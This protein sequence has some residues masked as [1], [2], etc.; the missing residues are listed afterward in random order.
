MP[1]CPE[2]PHLATQFLRWYCRSELLDEVEGDLYELF[3]RRIETK[4]KRRAEMLY[5]LNVLMFFQPD[6]IRK[7]KNYNA[8]N[9][10]AMV[11]NYF[12][13]GWRN[14]LINKGYS[15]INI[16][17]LAAGMVVTL[18][19][20]LWIYDEVSFNTYHQNYN[21]IA[22]VMRHQGRLDGERITSGYHPSALGELFRSS[23]ENYF[24]HV[25]M[26]RGSEEH[27]ISVEDKSFVQLGDF[28]QP[29]GP[30]MLTLNMLHGTRN[31]LR[32]MSSILLS[33]TLADKLF[34]DADPINK[35]LTIDGKSVV[36]VTGV[37]EDLPHNSDFRETSYIAPLD[38][39]FSMTGL[40][41]N[42]WDNFNMFLYVQ[43]RP[44]HNFDAASALIKDQLLNHIPEELAATGPEL[45]L[46]PMRKWHLFS[47]FKDGANVTSNRLKF[48]WLYGLIGLFVLLLACINFM[49][50]STARSEK[51]AKEIGVR[52]SMG[53]MRYQ[54][55]NQFLSES[56]LVA[57]FAFILSIAIVLLI[58]PWFNEIA[59]KEMRMPFTNPWFWMV[60]LGFTFFTGMLAGMYPALYLSSFNPVKSLKGTFRMGRYAALPR[61]VL[62]VVQFT[63]SMTLIIGTL[64]VD[65]QIQHAK[66]RP[67]G[68]TRDGLLMIPKRVSSLYGKYE[69]FRDEL[70]KTGTVVEVAE[71][72]YPLTNTLGNNGGF[73][74]PG[75]DPSFNPSFNTVSV[76][77][78]YG[79]TVDW[80]LLEGRDFSRDFRT[81]ISGVVITES[82]QKLMGLEDPIGVNL[83]YAYGYSGI[84]NFTILGV[85]KDMIKGDPFQSPYPAIMFLSETELS[86]MFIRLNPQVNASEALSNIE[87]IF[88]QIAPAAP[89]DYK[90]VDEEYDAKFRAEERIGK[91]AT[92][93]AVLAILISGLGLFGLAAFVAERRTKEIG[94]RK[95]LGA[96]VSQLWQMLS[97][98][99]VI[100][101]V[102]SCLI[103]I[104]VTYFFMHNWLQQYE[105]RTE[106]TWWIFA[107][108]GLGAFIITLLTVS[109]QSIKAA[110]A[111]PV[112]SLRNE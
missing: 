94:I 81:D 22:Q 64:I 93:F 9:A 101:I 63:V 2:P 6:Y 69:I 24:E 89:F 20:S 18:L 67:V 48:V 45:F 105:Y 80:K 17:G 88:K 42:V 55:V 32:D 14:L 82:A 21:S 85:V 83:K 25:V 26:R 95:V 75:K 53:S 109:F 46:H 52:K 99:F 41:P 97:Q 10:M 54:L 106:I 36:T 76:N 56:L 29:E 92:F 43:L 58:L 35:V 19:I 74:W 78:E 38:L 51:R 98:D 71:A 7:R 23:Y 66:N 72:N 59:G 86:W 28:M 70:K 111:N 12:K 37:Y 57:L 60:G 15:L 39:F 62:V 11:E 65:Q 33:K 5:C 40:D 44:Q 3:R 68:Y 107:A 100:L 50:L 8:T 30:A 108:A 84:Y 47:E 61:K 110:L 13:I 34:G 87:N 112:D 27:I 73:D 103:A 91:L 96:S 4:G 49:N 102:L 79:Q 16:G 77:Y 31:G 104:P 90:F 1:Y